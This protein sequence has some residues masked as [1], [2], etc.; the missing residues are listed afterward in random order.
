MNVSVGTGTYVVAVSGGVDSM[1][2]L[3]L[4]RKH[5]GLKLIIAHF[6]HGIR[7]NSAED[8]RLVQK[9]A[10][11]H[12]LTFVHKNGQL[13]PKTSSATARKARY[14]F[15]HQTL[16]ASNAKAII[17]AHHQDDLLETAILNLIRGT[18]RRGLSSLKSNGVILRPL[19]N[20]TKNQLIEYAVNHSL[21][22]REDPSNN[23]DRYTRNY[24]RHNILSRFNDG[25]KAQL[26]ILIK[27][28]QKINEEMDGHII[29]LLHAQPEISKLDRR[30]FIG[31]PHDIAKEVAHAWLQRHDVRNLTR[32]NIE[33]LIIQMKTGRISTKTDIDQ[34]HVL[35]ITKSILALEPADR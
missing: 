12:K 4:L 30:W 9:V 6:D 29:N 31:L 24:I 17:T 22:W 26:L 1:V 23:T 18:G 8:R 33:R 19:L 32:R 5:P 20:C 7:N 28:L 3:D 14:H 11:S 15:L 16:Q 13:G 2:L 34:G 10:Q 35:T 25:H 21:A 27:D